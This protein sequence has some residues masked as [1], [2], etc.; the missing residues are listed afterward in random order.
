VVNYI[1]KANTEIQRLVESGWKDWT[2]K[3]NSPK[4]L[5]NIKEID[6]SFPKDF[7]DPEKIN[8][9]SKGI[10][11]QTRAKKIL[12]ALS[13]NDLDILWEVGAGN[14]NVALP[15]RAA[16]KTVIAIEPLPS[17][18]KALTYNGIMAY[19]GT[20]KDMAFPDSSIYA[21]GVFDVLEH[22]EHPEELLQEIN[23][24]L[25]PGG[26][27]ITTVPANQW[28]FSDFD[29]SIGHFRRYSR[30]TLDKLLRENG[31][32]N[33]KVHY[34]FFSL[35]L[36]AFILR[37]IPYK[38]G[39]RRQYSKTIKSNKFLSNVMRLAYPLLFLI[40]KIEDK[41]RLPTGLSLISVSSK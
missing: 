18:A 37:T 29:S 27:L 5:P 32:Q 28:L 16:G 38:F 20:L 31:F 17:G 39:R 24:V 23:R 21:I 33:N 14:G 34:F 8:E 13:K 12:M 10:W 40:L 11:A 26:I 2:A 36:P 7:W 30:P 19:Q 15:L 3:V 25:K 4:T 22:L 9:E 41:F 6:V 1:E 35:V